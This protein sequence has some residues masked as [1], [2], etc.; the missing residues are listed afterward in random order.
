MSAATAAEI[1]A[2]RFGVGWIGTLGDLA[3][4]SCALLCAAIAVR[5]PRAWLAGVA[6]A[7]LTASEYASRSSSSSGSA[8]TA[9]GRRPDVISTDLHQLSVNGP[10]YDLPTCMSKFLHLGMPL[11][12]AIR[13]L[14]TV[15]L[16]VKSIRDVTPIPHNGCRPRKRRRV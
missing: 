16:E 9:A 12:E 7:V 6:A 8:L 14:Q 2:F 11:R 10:A 4:L 5:Q 15:G 1:N 3:W 13:A